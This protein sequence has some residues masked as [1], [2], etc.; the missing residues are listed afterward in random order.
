MD[1]EWL[2]TSSQP[3]SLL[4]WK[5][6]LQEGVCVC[7]GSVGAR[8]K[9]P[10]FIQKHH[11]GGGFRACGAQGGGEEAG[12]LNDQEEVGEKHLARLHQLHL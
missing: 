11:R 4:P 10:H 9:T 2:P 1:V 6:Q 3:A 5:Q 7:G 12:A 8:V